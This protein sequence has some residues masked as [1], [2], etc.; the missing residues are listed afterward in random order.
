M[1]ERRHVGGELCRDLVYALVL[2]DPATRHVALLRRTFAPGGDLGE[3]TH[4]FGGVFARLE[5]APG[6]VRRRRVQRHLR[7]RLHFLGYPFETAIARQT[8]AQPQID[9]G[10]VGDVAQR[11][12][13]LLVAQRPARPVGKARA[14]VDVDLQFLANER[15]IGDLIAESGRHRRHLGVEDR[16]RH[17]AEIDEDFHVLAAGVKDLEH[18]RIGQDVEKRF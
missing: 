11:I 15:I 17:D 13:Q 16:R 3:D 18:V 14:L 5:P 12:L 7:Q 10:Q 4:I 2:E 6:L 1:I 8:V 9:I